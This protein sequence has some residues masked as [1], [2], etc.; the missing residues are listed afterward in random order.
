MNGQHEET[1]QRRHSQN[2]LKP[3][4]QHHHQTESLCVHPKVPQ[5]WEWLNSAGQARVVGRLVGGYHAVGGDVVR[6]AAGGPE[7]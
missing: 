4:E 3:D 7:A 5:Q 6:V 2:R 1:Y